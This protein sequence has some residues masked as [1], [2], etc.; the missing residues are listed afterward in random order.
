MP[1]RQ[2]RKIILDLCGGTGAWS[3]PYKEAGYDVRLI[4]LPEYDVRTYMPPENVYGVLAAPP[5]TEFSSSGARW[6]K[7]KDKKG[8]TIESQGVVIACLRIMAICK[9]KWWA[10]ENPVGR[11]RRWLGDPAYI[12]N[13]CDFGDPYTKRTLLWG[14]FNPPIKTPVVPVEGSKLHRLPPGPNRAMLRGITPS[15]FAQAF[16]EANP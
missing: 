13:P 14:K 11:L 16:Y 8:I 1:N 2:R 12:F 4:T 3:R 5:C 15:G 10:L 6:F 7:Q 9:P